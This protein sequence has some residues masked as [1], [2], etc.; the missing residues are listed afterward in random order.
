[1]STFLCDVCDKRFSKLGNL[2]T[3]KRLHSGVKPF[4]CDVCGAQ[5][6]QKINL[7][8]HKLTH[9]GERRFVCNVCEK[10]FKTRAQ[11]K[12]GLLQRRHNHREGFGGARRH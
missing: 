4:V 3:H 9:S 5:F 1:M 2:T 12:E 7:T 11:C 8:S 6:S 10:L